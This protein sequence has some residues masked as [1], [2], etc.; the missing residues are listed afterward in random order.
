ME[1]YFHDTDPEKTPE[2]LTDEEL[3]RAIRCATRL[4]ATALHIHGEP[5]TTRWRD[6]AN[7]LRPAYKPYKRN[8][9]LTRWVAGCAAHYHWTFWY[10][11]AL[12]KGWNASGHG[13]H[14]C[15]NFLDHMELEMTKRRYMPKTMRRAAC[16]PKEWLRDQDEAVRVAWSRCIATLNAPDGCFFGVLHMAE[17]YHQAVSSG[18]ARGKAWLRSHAVYYM[19]ASHT[20]RDHNPE[21][22]ARAAVRQ[23]KRKR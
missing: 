6:Q 9:V 13:Q 21:A 22:N 18:P 10:A 19:Y 23:Q 17:H 16:T 2:R 1:L 11:R 5:I 14:N 15:A 7:R 12:C 8:N 20:G 4:L 3:D